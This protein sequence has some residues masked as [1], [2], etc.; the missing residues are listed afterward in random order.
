M[1]PMKLIFVLFLL[2]GLV[3]SFLPRGEN[4]AQ[5]AMTYTCYTHPGGKPDKMVTVMADSN[6]E[7]VA[8]AIAKFKSIGVDPVGVTCR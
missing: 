8:L 5:A 2:V 6:G 7:A 3:V 1:K 4:V